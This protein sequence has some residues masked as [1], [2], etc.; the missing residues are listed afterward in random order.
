MEVP[1][2]EIKKICCQFEWWNRDLILLKINLVRG[3]VKKITILPSER[4]KQIMIVQEYKSFPI[5]VWRHSPSSSG[6]DRFTNKFKFM[7]VSSLETYNLHAVTSY[8]YIT[9]LGIQFAYSS[10][11]YVRQT[12]GKL[13][14]SRTFV[15]EECIK[16]EYI[17]KRVYYGVDQPSWKAWCPE[18]WWRGGTYLDLNYLD[19]HS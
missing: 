4:L 6:I 9:I 3:W 18:C 10:C 12:S 1:L 17:G 19:F 11:C 5:P 15:K 8:S 13:S 14:G 2:K 7:D 16:C